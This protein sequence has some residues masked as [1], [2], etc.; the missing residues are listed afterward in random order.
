MTQLAAFKAEEVDAVVGL[1]PKNAK[2]LEAEGK[3]TIVSRGTG[4]ANAIAGDA[5]HPDSIYADIRV[6]Q[7]VSHAIDWKAICDSVGYGY[8]QP[9]NQQCGPGVW[10]YNPDLKG[11]P[12]NPDRARELL[13]EAGY[14]DGFK[15]K[16]ICMNTP[17]ANVDAL[18]AVQGYL[19]EVGIDAELDIAERGRFYQ[20]IVGGGWEDSMVFVQGGAGVKAAFGLRLAMSSKSIAFGSMLHVPEVDEVIYEACVTADFETK[21]A[22]VHEALRMITDDY[23]VTT[24]GWSATYIAA[25]HPYVHDDG[26]GMSAETYSFTPEDAWIEK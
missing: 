1:D 25:K 15:T 20:I 16:I 3:Y 24:V 11:Y 13:A 26:L 9:T 14:P 21:K 2:S 23:C 5:A 12:Y 22:L 18:T 10:G 17:K 4:G 8:W 19:S 6:R 7:A